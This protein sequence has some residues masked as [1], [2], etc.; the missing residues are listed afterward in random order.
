M[1][2][3]RLK[4]SVSLRSAAISLMMLAP[5]ALPALAR[6]QSVAVSA[7]QYQNVTISFNGVVANDVSRS[8]TVR[9][10]DGTI[11]AYTGPVPAFS[12]AQGQAVTVSFDARLPTKAYFDGLL[13]AGA[14]LP[15]GGIYHL[16]VD[17]GA[18]GTGNLNNATTAT[19][20]GGLHA[21][22]SMG[23]MP[24]NRLKLIYDYNT[25]AYS[26]DGTGAFMDTSLLGAG[27][28][29]DLASG[30]VVACTTAC[31]DPPGQDNGA[32]SLQSG[33]DANTL[34]TAFARIYDSMGQAWG[35][36]SMTLT[37][38]WSLPKGGGGAV[39][40]PE[41]SML[42]LFGA[43]VLVPVWRRRRAR[44]KQG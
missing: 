43:G 36:F 2:L 19:I 44:R 35:N 20:T 25:D 5:V 29:Y 7:P 27:Y 24:Y 30:K 39:Q 38:S 40:V 11:A 8:L 37:G 23:E 12:Y 15:A 6:A 32:L 31:I 9:Q 21:V 34:T 22:S 4:K 3:N 41:P 14:T 1:M 26:L 10:S 18:P 33:A 42:A 16:Q 28:Y 13:G 17:N